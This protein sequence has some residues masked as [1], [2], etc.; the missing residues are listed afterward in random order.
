MSA[1]LVALS[2]D[3]DARVSDTTDVASVLNMYRASTFIRNWPLHVQWWVTKTAVWHA[4]LIRFNYDAMIKSLILSAAVLYVF[5]VDMLRYA[6]TLTSD[7]VILTFDLWPW[8]WSVSPVTWWNPL[9][10]LSEIEQ[11][12]AELLRSECLTLWPWT[13]FTC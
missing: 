13:C 5:T 1:Y 8:I 6:V 3:V 9:P 10:N 4:V 11:S 7:P 2:I 12:A